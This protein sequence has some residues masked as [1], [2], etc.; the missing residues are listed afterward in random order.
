MILHFE[1]LWGP[2][3]SQGGVSE[4]PLVGHGPCILSHFRMDF[5]SDTFHIRLVPDLF[6][7]KI[8]TLSRTG[9]PAETGSEYRMRGV[10]HPPSCF[11]VEFVWLETAISKWIIISSLEPD[12]DLSEAASYAVEKIECKAN[13]LKE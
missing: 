8:L 5:P 3:L 11:E 13:S 6:F 10:G 2:F 1:D 7:W 4:L 9:A 12:R